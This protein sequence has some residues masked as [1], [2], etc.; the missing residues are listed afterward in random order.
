MADNGPKLMVDNTAFW[1]VLIQSLWKKIKASEKVMQLG[2]KR[3]L[4]LW[5]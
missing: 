2:K 5:N 3:F 4:A 1:D